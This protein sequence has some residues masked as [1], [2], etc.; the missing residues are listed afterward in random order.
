MWVHMSAPSASESVPVDPH[1]GQRLVYSNME[2][3]EYYHNIDIAVLIST[4]VGGQIFGAYVWN[5]CG[6]L[7]L[8]SCRRSPPP[9]VLQD[10]WVLEGLAIV[11]LCFHMMPHMVNLCPDKAVS[12]DAALWQWH[13]RSQ[14]KHLDAH[15]SSDVRNCVCHSLTWD[16]FASLM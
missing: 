16:I 3:S 9:L 12:T 6:V 2:M 14:L 13:G 1:V 4:C 11:Y 8:Y 7:E 15:R 10:L 5:D